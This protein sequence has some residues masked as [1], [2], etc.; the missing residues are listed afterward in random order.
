MQRKIQTVVRILLGALFLFGGMA[1]FF[2]TPPALTG[3]M[4][5]DFAG[6]AASKYF[7][8]LLKGTEFF[9]GAGLVL[10]FF[11]RL[12]LVILAPVGLNILLVHL[13]LEPSGLPLGITLTVAI[14]YLAFFSPGYS[15][16]IKKLFVLKPRVGVTY[17]V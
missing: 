14:L 1:F 15:P 4:A 11:V 9:C 6:L 7:F 10:G 2:T 16:T 13:F 12:A 17:E 5:T 8:Y 3:N